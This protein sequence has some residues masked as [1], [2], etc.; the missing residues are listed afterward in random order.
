[1][2]SRARRCRVLRPRCASQ[3]SNAEGT[4]PMAFW[5]KVRRSFSESSLNAA[6]PMR[7]SCVFALVVNFWVYVNDLRS[8]H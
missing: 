1:M 5:R 8:V 7:T 2:A 6:T 3:Q 4:A